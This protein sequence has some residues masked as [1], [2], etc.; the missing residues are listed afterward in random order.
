MKKITKI[1]TG[2]VIGTLALVGAIVGTCLGNTYSNHF[3]EASINQVSATKAPNNNL[4]IKQ[5]TVNK[6]AP[7]TSSTSLPTSHSTPKKPTNVVSSLLSSTNSSFIF[8]CP[9]DNVLLLEFNH[10]G[11]N[12]LTLLG[13]KKKASND[14]VIPNIV[15]HDNAMYVITNIAAGAFYGQ[16]L[17]SVTFSNNLQSIGILA[18]AN[19]QLTSLKL[20]PNLQSIGDKAFI[21]NPFP[22]AYAVYLPTNTTWSKNWLTCPFGCLNNYTKMADGIQWVIQNSAVYSFQPNQN[23]WIIVSYTYTTNNLTNNNWTTTSTT[24][25]KISTSANPTQHALKSIGTVNASIADSIGDNL[26]NYCLWIENSSGSVSW[27]FYFDQTTNTFNVYIPTDEYDVANVLFGWES[28]AT[29]SLSLY[30]PHTGSYDVNWQNVSGQATVPPDYVSNPN[31]GNVYTYNYHEGDI[32]TFSVNNSSGDDNAYIGT[33]FNV[34]DVNNDIQPSNL[35][36][37][38]TKS[39]TWTNRNDLPSLFTIKPQGIFPT[40]N[41]TTLSNVCYDPTTGKLQLVGSSL[42]NIKF[43]IDINNKQEG[44]ITSDSEGNLNSTLTIPTG[45]NATTNFTLVPL[46]TNVIVPMPYTDH[47][48]GYN[49]KLT[50]LDLNING[51]S[52]QLLFDGFTNALAT[53]DISNFWPAYANPYNNF[54]V[55][56][57]AGSGTLSSS[58]SLTVEVTTASGKVSNYTFNANTASSSTKATTVAA[59]NSFLA[60][61]PYQVNDTYTFGGSALN[62]NYVYING[63][64]VPYWSTYNSSTMQTTVSFQVTSNNIIWL[65]DNS[66]GIENNSYQN[67]IN[68]GDNTS[69]ANDGYNQGSRYWQA[70]Y[71]QLACTPEDIWTDGNEGANWYDPNNLMIQVATEISSAYANPANQI[72]ATVQWV[73]DNMTY[74]TSYNYFHTIRQTFQHMEGECGNYSSLTMALL[75]LEGF[76]TRQITGDAD[77]YNDDG[78]TVNDYGTNVYVYAHTWMQVW[79]PSLQEWITLDPTWDWVDFGELTCILNYIRKNMTINFVEWPEKG[80]N[81]YYDTYGTYSYKSYEYDN[82][83]SYFNGCEYNALYNLGRHFNIPAGLDD[84]D[85]TSDFALGIVSLINWSANPSNSI[86]AT[87]QTYNFEEMQATDY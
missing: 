54:S 8:T 87:S 12:T 57:T 31:G 20:P 14:L 85:Y 36:E 32:L 59:L 61:I 64:Y 18:F 49:P 17:K 78:C 82:Y 52:T 51:L 33:N 70:T 6:I 48:Q 37:Y 34:N 56:S 58:G 38:Y 44:T 3:N 5:K 30:D 11:S 73:Y 68:Q 63:Q 74:S 19:N 7:T 16:G 15:I 2:S 40:L 77:E 35:N 66:N 83:F 39:W 75:K 53:S 60:K 65:D 67:A 10:D 50:I 62:F 55:G 24:W 28:N 29:F 23:S 41:P 69:Q 13:F 84:D 25:N 76:V 86:N 4:T 21:S 27:V 71:G 42:P 26:S 43:G 45:L 80:T 81:A 47:L 46:N 9:N 79:M 1:I 72:L 22:H